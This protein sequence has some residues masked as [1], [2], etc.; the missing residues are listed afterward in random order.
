VTPAD[1]LGARTFDPFCAT[2]VLAAIN[3]LADGTHSKAIADLITAGKFRAEL[4]MTLGKVGAPRYANFIGRYKDDPDESVRR[5]VAIAL[6]LID[7]D[8]VALPVLVQLLARGTAKDAFVVKWD[9]AESLVKVAK[10]QSGDGARRRLVELLR[11]PDG[12]TVALAARGLALA[13]DPR[14]VDRLRELTAHAEPRVRQEALLALG[15]LKDAGA[16]GSVTQRLKDDSLAV[17]ACAV[18]ALGAH[19]GSIRGRAAARGGAGSARLRAAAR[20]AQAARGERRDAARARRP[21]GIRS[22]RDA[23]AGAAT[24]EMGGLDGPPIPPDARRR[25]GGAGAPLDGRVSACGPLAPRPRR[26]AA[27]RAR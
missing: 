20:R 5:G 9:A 3:D 7:N 17:R 18:Y 1:E 25:P 26:G 19:R 6:G 27:C 24:I 11:E 22:A 14:G 13:R 12:V 10:R 15:S 23:T 4:L 2:S 16:R 8:A 21:R